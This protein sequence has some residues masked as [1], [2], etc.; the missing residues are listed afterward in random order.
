MT[1][2][3]GARRLLAAGLAAALPLGACAVGPDFKTPPPPI[4]NRYAPT[5]PA[6]A[7]PASGAAPADTGQTIAWGAPVAADWWRGFA[8]PQLDALV[9]QALR[10]NPDLKSADAA[11]RQGREL[12]AA[13]RGALLPSIDAS[14]EGQRAN[15]SA[16]L[17]PV[18]SDSRS[19]YSLQ[20]AQLTVTYA[21]DVFGGVRR[22]TE[23][24]AAQAESQRFQYEAARTS[25]IANVVAAAVQ[26][27]ALREQVEAVRTAAAAGRDMLAFTRRQAQL[28]AL[29]QA[30]V[31]AQEATLAQ[32]E[33][34]IPPLLKALAAQQSALAVLLGR[35]PGEDPLPGVTMDGLVLPHDL[36]VALPSQLVRQRPDVRAA[37][38]N[39]HA[40][41][42][43]V[44][45]AIAARL[46]NLTLSAAAGGAGPALQSLFS[47]GNDF[48]TLT[49][50][51]TQPIFAGGALL[52]RQKAAEAALD[53][54]KAQYRSTVLGALKNVADTLDALAQDA[55]GLRAAEVAQS[56][57][58]RSL[59]F[60]RRQLELG[61]VG[62]L[63]E[64]SA[65]QA[66]VQARSALASARAARYA[67][68]A[69]LFQALGGG[70]ADPAQGR[71]P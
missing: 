50:G 19:P 21:L 53:Q 3:T 16:V 32:A 59:A 65:E 12:L 42:A 17:S 62:A 60:S 10:A 31:A 47:Q 36:P 41:S 49:A 14:Y 54:A 64:R 30:D 34:A 46:P 29:G 35:E 4:S 43:G 70:W 23:A 39:L 66:D 52:H 26:E 58:G 56:A 37:E 27:A 48:W 18:L 55:D 22:A 51:V 45:V 1:R 61:Q 7:I 15:T 24:A 28:G 63:A 13:Q 8:S 9:E 71:R 33:Q 40:A 44:G 57:A 20:T 11:L 6:S 67:D 25:L 68:T 5:P 2:S 69:A 38:A